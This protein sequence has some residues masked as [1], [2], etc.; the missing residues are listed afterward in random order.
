M[1]ENDVLP[2]RFEGSDHTSP[3]SAQTEYLSEITIEQLEEVEE[4]TGPPPVAP[5]EYVCKDRDRTQPKR[6]AE[7]GERITRDLGDFVASGHGYMVE[8][9]STATTLPTT[10]RYCNGPLPLPETADFVCEFPHLPWDKC[11][12][13]WCVIKEERL[14]RDVGGQPEI[15]NEK[16]CRRAQKRD[17]MRR[18]RARKKAEKQGMAEITASQITAA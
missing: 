17:E 18:Y 8:S 7:A 2:E 14:L 11:R 15:C 16:A 13:N 12:C 4:L 10:C 6:D 5:E 1:Q 3:T 9:F